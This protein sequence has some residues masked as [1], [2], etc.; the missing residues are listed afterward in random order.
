MGRD[1][2]PRF[3]AG[4]A[5]GRLGKTTA[6]SGTVIQTPTAMVSDRQAGSLL[7]LRSSNATF[8]IRRLEKAGVAE[9]RPMPGDG[10][11]KLVALTARFS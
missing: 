9:R 11:V 5:K 4:E 6:G 3:S 2:P 1:F 8:I 10:R 7:G